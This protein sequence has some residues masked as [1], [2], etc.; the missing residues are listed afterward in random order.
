[1]INPPLQPLV[2]P[3]PTTP[4]HPPRNEILTNL[5]RRERLPPTSPPIRKRNLESR[6]LGRWTRMIMKN[7]SPYPPITSE[8]GKRRFDRVCKYKRPFHPPAM[9]PKLMRWWSPP[10]HRYHCNRPLNPRTRK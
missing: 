5:N 9:I 8:K 1:M 10:H 6:P 7:T 4:T 2:F 3:P